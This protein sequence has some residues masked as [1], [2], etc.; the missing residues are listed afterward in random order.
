MSYTESRYNSLAFDAGSPVLNRR[1]MLEEKGFG[2]EIQ[3]RR[4]RQRMAAEAAETEY[5]SKLNKFSNRK[6]RQDVPTDV[7]SWVLNNRELFKNKDEAL[8][9]YRGYTEWLKEGNKQK[10]IER[11]EVHE[12]LTK[13]IA[14]DTEHAISLGGDPKKQLPV[15]DSGKMVSTPLTYRETQRGSD[16]PKS[17]FPGSR[18]YNIHQNKTDSFDK[19]QMEELD[20][21]DDWRKSAAYYFAFGDD[22]STRLNHSDWLA[23]QQGEVSADELAGGKRVDDQDTVKRIEDIH[24]GEVRKSIRDKWSPESTSHKRLSKEKKLLAELGYV[25]PDKMTTTKLPLE[26]QAKA[27]V[28]VK[29]PTVPDV[30]NVKG[31]KNYF[32]KIKN[33]LTDQGFQREAARLAGQSNVPWT[34]IAGDFVG[35]VFDGMAVAANPRDK[36]AIMEL[37]MSG[38]QLTTSTVGSALIAIPDP[39]TSGLGYVIMKAGDKVGQLER[40]WNMSREGIYGK[41]KKIPEL[42]ENKTQKGKMIQ[43]IADDIKL[44]AKSVGKPAYG[45]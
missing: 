45:F 7:K 26:E 34:N 10:D 38:T 15:D 32:D 37:V 16:D 22:A 43:D 13:G 33:H 21:P 31:P 40:I 44:D 2:G 19:L 3:E 24:K 39:V 12:K 1:Q 42:I 30:R 14:A 9:G 25:E 18:Y 17:K 36:K 6:V 23:L 5:Q 35:V 11:A 4:A 20:K 28:L 27:N 41:H 8:E 29:N